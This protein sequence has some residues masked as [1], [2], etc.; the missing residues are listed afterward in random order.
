MKVELDSRYAV[1]VLFLR[2]RHQC[3]D[4]LASRT[5]LVV[6]LQDS[7]NGCSRLIPFFI[8]EQEL[9][10]RLPHAAFRSLQRCLHQGLEKPLVGADVTGGHPLQ[11]FGHGVRQDLAKLPW[12]GKSEVAGAVGRAVAQLDHLLSAARAGDMLP[13]HHAAQLLVRQEGPLLRLDRLQQTAGLV[14]QGSL[15]LPHLRT[16]D[17]RDQAR[18]SAS[19]HGGHQGLLLGQL[20][21]LLLLGSSDFDGHDGLAAFRD[22]NIE[23]RAFPHSTHA[24]SQLKVFR[25]SHNGALAVGRCHEVHSPA[26]GPPGLD[27]NSKGHRRHAF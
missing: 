17:L 15:N 24:A 5:L 11:S 7:H 27:L 8:G 21:Q 3:P 10:A 6:P 12:L 20:R 18:I 25:P 9:A 14:D 23:H 26:I 22:G 13:L 4:A 19:L 2:M 1:A 16:G